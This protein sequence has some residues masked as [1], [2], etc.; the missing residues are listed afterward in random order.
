MSTQSSILIS[1]PHFLCKFALRGVSLQLHGDA[2]DRA[3]SC[4]PD[5]FQLQKHL[6]RMPR[7]SC[8][9]V[10]L[11]NTWLARSW[12]F[13]NFS[14]LLYISSWTPNVP[15]LIRM[16]WKVAVS[17]MKEELGYGLF[18]SLCAMKFQCWKGFE[19]YFIQLVHFMTGKLWSIFF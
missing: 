4:F 7:A 11:G 5:S 12:S 13:C 14:E 3:P 18:S 1:I 17:R 16:P 8:P 9:T 2:N 19:N 10:L 15:F 6:G